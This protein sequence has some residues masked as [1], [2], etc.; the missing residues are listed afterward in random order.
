VKKAVQVF[1]VKEGTVEMHKLDEAP[2]SEKAFWVI[3]TA[4]TYRGE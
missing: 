2:S 4:S 3:P 1:N